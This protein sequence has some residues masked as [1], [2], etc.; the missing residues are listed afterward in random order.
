M[1]C[2]LSK[3]LVALCVSG[4]NCL[5]L[6]SKRIPNLQLLN[7]AITTKPFM[8]P[9]TT[10]SSSAIHSTSPTFFTTGT[11]AFTTLPPT[12]PRLSVAERTESLQALLVAPHGSG[13]WSILTDRD[14]LHRSLRFPNFN[15]AFGFMT[16]VAM[17]AEKMDHHPEVSRIS[18]LR[19][20]EYR[21]L[22][23]LRI[24]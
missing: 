7:S 10:V 2:R 11:P 9:S 24:T 3:H 8:L 1:R 21:R 23:A 6:N 13:T 16:R 20:G 19:Q 14:A 5:I 18:L 22:S 12:V 17:L 15:S 4:N